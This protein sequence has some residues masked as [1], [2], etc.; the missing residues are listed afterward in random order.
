MNG[1]TVIVALAL[2]LAPPDHV[3][4]VKYG[5]VELTPAN[6]EYVVPD[7]NVGPA[8]TVELAGVDNVAPV[9][10]PDVELAK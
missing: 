2:A 1:A 3:A 6:G 7:K 9:K 5:I 8:V 10:K 4:P